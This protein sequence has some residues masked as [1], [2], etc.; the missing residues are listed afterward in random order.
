MSQ[1]NSD[2]AG[3]EHNCQNLQ[4]AIANVP[5]RLAIAELEEKMAHLRSLMTRFEHQLTDGRSAYDVGD[6]LDHAISTLTEM[7][8]PP[9][10]QSEA[11]VLAH[12]RDIMPSEIRIEHVE[13]TEELTRQ[14]NA[15]I[16]AVQIM[17]IQF[18]TERQPPNNNQFSG[19]YY[20]HEHTHVDSNL[21][22][23]ALRALDH[24]TVE[25]RQAYLDRLDW[26]SLHFR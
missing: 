12:Q 5:K 17:P 25:E 23:T 16:T 6:V 14:Q 9:V 1:L 21:N 13:L 4:N 7:R 15:L 26:I 22:A 3:L 8:L 24:L 18:L 19:T 10:P 20:N 11:D 2:I